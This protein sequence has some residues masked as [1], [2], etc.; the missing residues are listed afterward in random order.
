MSGFQGN[1]NANAVLDGTT[2]PSL[3]GWAIQQWYKWHV[4]DPVSAKEIARN[5]AIYTIQNNRNPFIDHPEFVALIWQCTNLLPVVLMDFTAA[6]NSAL[7]NLNWMVTGEAN[8]KYYEVERSEDGVRFSAV[9]KVN[10]T[11][12]SNYSFSDNR[13]P[14]AQVIYY[15]LRMVDV[16]G[17]YTYSKIVPVRL[18]VKG[19]ITIFPNPAKD[20]VTITLQKPLSSNSQIK[21][22][23]ATGRLVISRFAAA[24]QNNFNIA[25]N[26]LPAGRYI[27]SIVN[28]DAVINESFV[29][30]K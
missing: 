19:R 9:G 16:D 12:Q 26:K 1:G 5:N 3:D 30:S 24:A 27:I 20:F 29:I 7:I 2:W 13:L 8:F 10:G 14:A 6:G 4:Q 21:I 17:R 25:V 15:R 22:T 11:Q 28:N 18:S 23:D